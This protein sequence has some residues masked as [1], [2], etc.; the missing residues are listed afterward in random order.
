MVHALFMQSFGTTKF[1]YIERQ[2]ETANFISRVVTILIE[3]LNLHK[4]TITSEV[5]YFFKIKMA[6][7][8]SL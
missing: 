3:L 8:Y 6:V 7:I 5:K 4:N 1:S 2:Q